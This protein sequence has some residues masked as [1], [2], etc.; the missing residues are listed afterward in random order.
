MEVLGRACADYPYLRVKIALDSVAKG[1]ATHEQV[2]PFVGLSTEGWKEYYQNFQEGD[3]GRIPRVLSSLVPAR[4]LRFLTGFTDEQLNILER[5]ISSSL[6]K[7]LS[8]FLRR[9]FVTWESKAAR[10]R[11]GS[12]GEAKR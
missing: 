9:A 5:N 3:L 6:Q 2:A 12:A 4:D 10:E 8:T 1:Y 7:Q 11:L